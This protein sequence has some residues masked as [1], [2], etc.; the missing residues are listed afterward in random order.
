MQMVFQNPFLSLDARQPVG[1]AIAEVM[2]HHGRV[3]KSKIDAR[4]SELL[5]AVG[6]AERG[7]EPASA[8]LRRTMPARRDR[9]C[10]GRRTGN[11][12]AG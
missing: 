11:A 6:L 2:R 4:V 9:P 8:A 12:G 1:A 3:E 5:D 10:T 7:D